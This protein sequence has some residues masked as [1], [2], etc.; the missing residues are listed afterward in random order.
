MTIE[1]EI[2]LSL[3]LIIVAMVGTV[4]LRVWKIPAVEAKLDAV[5]KD[6]DRNRTTIH[7]INNTIQH[8]ET[9]IAVLERE[10][11][12]SKLQQTESRS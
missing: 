6:T 4:L 5:V 9:R 12:W 3:I 8:H 2:I 11:R 1:I 7:T 10:E